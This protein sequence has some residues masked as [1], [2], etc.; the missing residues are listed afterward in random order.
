MVGQMRLTQHDVQ[1]APNV[2][3]MNVQSRGLFM[4]ILD[5]PYLT[6]GLAFVVGTTLN[7][8]TIAVCGEECISIPKEIINSMLDSMVENISQFLS[9]SR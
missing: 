5:D 4:T 7:R 9:P 2:A 6:L 3:P 1:S 8:L